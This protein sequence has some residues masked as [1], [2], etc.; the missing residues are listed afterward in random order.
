V[1]IAIGSLGGRPLMNA[2]KTI[3]QKGASRRVQSW[4]QSGIEG[5]RRGY[6]S[7]AGQ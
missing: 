5:D 3:P 2:L 4:G 6:K 1:V 7:G